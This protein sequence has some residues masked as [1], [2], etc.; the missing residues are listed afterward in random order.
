MD[1]DTSA[2]AG[3]ARRGG[4]WLSW[5]TLA[6]LP[7]A[8]AAGPLGVDALW[9]LTGV[10]NL[11]HLAVAAAL[12][13]G[14]AALRVR[15]RWLAAGL[16]VHPV[17]FCAWAAPRLWSGPMPAESAAAA[18]LTLL[19]WNLGDAVCSAEEAAAFL[20]RSDA[21]L[22]AL[23]ELNGAVATR[24]VDEF[25]SRFPHRVLHPLGVDGRGVFSRFPIRSHEFLELEGRRRHLRVELDVGGRT[26]HL[27]VVHLALQAALLGE[28]E[29]S[30]RDLGPL[31][32]TLL[33]RPPGLLLGDFNSSESSAVYRGLAARG[34]VD[35]FREA[36]SGAGFSFP[37][38]FRYWGVPSVP[39]V[40]IDHV[41][42]TAGIVATE[43]RFG[44]DGGSDHLPL[45]VRL[46]FP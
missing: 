3:G 45:T 42:R 40:R 34:L 14:L 35:T 20:R 17:L 16:L 21:D 30:V 22:V 13:L 28:R 15:R 18:D 1:S 5:A 6:L 12:V 25:G 26:L 8:W 2:P 33:T 23:C 27:V 7:L 44:P 32:D 36:G 31:V 24:L 19:C 11:L 39:L 43:A 41:W 10:A 38:P 37:L 9:P 29:G 4:R 46:R